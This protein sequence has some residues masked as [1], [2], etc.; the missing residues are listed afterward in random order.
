MSLLNGSKETSNKYSALDGNGLGKV[1][2]SGE[3]IKDQAYSMG[4][5]K[6]LELKKYAEDG[7][8]TWKV[9]GFVAGG[10]LVSVAFLDF[11]SHL[12]SLSPF[13]AVLDIYIFLFGAITVVLEFK[14]QFLTK[15]YIEMLRTEAF[16]LYKP[17]GRAAF[18]VFVGILLIAKG[19]FLDLLVGLYTVCVGGAVYYGATQA[20]VELNKLKDVHFKTVE[21]IEACFKKFDKD[22]SG[23][24]DSSELDALTTQLM[25]KPL[26][27]NELASAQFILDGDGNGQVEMQEFIDW[28]RSRTP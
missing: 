18:Y 21:E 26:T 6:F 11:F 13:S 16:F 2:E 17:Y 22:N 9:M 19:G 27:P 20:L 4:K 5:Q 3:L 8:Y 23:S 12:F 28:W 14:D 10:L 25:G 24:L 1:L 7:N 15:K